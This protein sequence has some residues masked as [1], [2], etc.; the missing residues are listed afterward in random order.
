MAIDEFPYLV[1]SSETVLS[2]FQSF[3]D[4]QRTE[5]TSTLVLCG[6]SISVMESDV[7]GHESPLYGRRTA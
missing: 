5:S 1:E 2:A 3:V 7:M 6:S 4:T